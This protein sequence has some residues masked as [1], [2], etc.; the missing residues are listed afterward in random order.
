ME[1]QQAAVD[2]S[3]DLEASTGAITSARER[4]IN[5]AKRVRAAHNDHTNGLNRLL[6]E[7][8]I[9]CE[10]LQK[11]KK[12]S[13]QKRQVFV[14]V[15]ACV[16]ACVCARA[17]ACVPV[18]ACQSF[19]YLYA[20]VRCACFVFACVHTSACISVALL[21]SSVDFGVVQN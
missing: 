4:L 17:C 1:L 21:C 10:G 6:S 14:L 20:R 3:G 18:R 19:T 2:G 16:R 15:C 13:V 8:A 12:E 7:F 11:K 5:M 9:A